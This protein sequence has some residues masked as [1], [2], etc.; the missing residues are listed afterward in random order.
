[1]EGMNVVER[2]MFGLRQTLK[3]KKV[4]ESPSFAA[5]VYQDSRKETGRRISFRRTD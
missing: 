1:M 5:V 4:V 3:K 2:G